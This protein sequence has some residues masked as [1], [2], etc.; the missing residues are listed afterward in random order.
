MFEAYLPDCEKTR[1]LLPRLEKA[2]R[3]GLTFTVVEKD[4]EA[5]VTWDCIPHK[6]SIHGGKSG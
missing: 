1:R 3:Q 5:M 2:F 6:T 4:T